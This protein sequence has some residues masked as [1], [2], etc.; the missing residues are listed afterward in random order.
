MAMA[1]RIFHPET[2]HP[3]PYQKD[4]GPDASKGLNY[5]MAGP[6]ITTKTAH[7]VKEAHNLLTN[8]FSDEELRQIPVMCEGTR[9]ETGATYLSLAAGDRQE[10]RAKGDEDVKWD[11]LFVAKKDVPY[12]LWNRLLGVGDARRTTG[13]G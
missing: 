1:R 5:G 2:K 7:E 13:P 10:I 11:D 3:E 6:P 8:E 4:L 12:E 9:L